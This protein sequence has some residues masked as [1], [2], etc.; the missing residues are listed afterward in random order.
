MKIL[1]AMTAA[2]EAGTGLTLLAAP[3]TVALILLGSPLDSPAGLA[4]Q[5]RARG[6]PVGARSGL[7]DRP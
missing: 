4:D 7:L 3:S 2:V 6:S 5:S 1:L